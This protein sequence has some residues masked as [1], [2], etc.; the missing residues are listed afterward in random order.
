M[1]G[2]EQAAQPQQGDGGRGAPGGNRGKQEKTAAEEAMD[3]RVKKAGEMDKPETSAEELRQ[4]AEKD[5]QDNLDRAAANLKAAAGAIGDL[6]PGIGPE[7]SNTDVLD[8]GPNDRFR[9]ID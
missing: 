5:T 6:A 3:A 1:S 8:M 4:A 7:S 2:E 9:S